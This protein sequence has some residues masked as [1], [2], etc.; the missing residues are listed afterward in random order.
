MKYKAGDRIEPFT[1]KTIKGEDVIIPDPQ[2]LFTHIQFVR[3]GG[4]PVT[5]THLAPFKRASRR[6]RDTGI[7]EVIFFYSDLE[8]VKKTQEGVRIDIV[9]DP[10]KNYYRQFGVETSPKSMQNMSAI[11]AWYEGFITWKS[12]RNYG[13]N[14]PN[15]L[16]A[17][18]LIAPNG[19]ICTCRYGL[20]AFDQWQVNEM[21]NLARLY[22]PTAHLLEPVPIPDEVEDTVVAG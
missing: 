6:I 4:D 13:E 18:F 3:W 16:P 9:A 19:K 20:H 17:D 12:N 10:A 2:A 1:V 7:R 21:L 15:G 5:M 8:E 22:E 11:K 14:G